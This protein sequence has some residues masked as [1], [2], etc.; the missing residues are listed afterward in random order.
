VGE[1]AHKRDRLRGGISCVTV[2]AHGTLVSAGGLQ[3]SSAYAAPSCGAFAHSC[4]W[5]PYAAN[6]RSVFVAH[7]LE[8]HTTLTF[9]YRVSSGDMCSEC[10]ARHSHDLACGQQRD[11]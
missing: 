10:D 1:V 7:G 5:R 2:A 3:L 8:W 9:I 11:H 6:L 4:R